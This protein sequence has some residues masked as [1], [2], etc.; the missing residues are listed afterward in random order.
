VGGVRCPTSGSEKRRKI[1]IPP[2]TEGL[3]KFSFGKNSQRLEM[4]TSDQYKYGKT[5]LGIHVDGLDVKFARISVCGKRIVLRNLGAVTL[6]SPLEKSP[7]KKSGSLMEGEDPFDVTSSS[8]DE[9]DVLKGGVTEAENNNSVMVNLF[10]RFPAK[11]HFLALTV[12]EPG[13]FYQ[14]LSSDFGLKGEKLKAKLVQELAKNFP[15]NT[16]LLPDRIDSITASDDSL[17]CVALRDGIPVLKLVEEVRPFIG[18]RLPRIS[19]AES[20]DIAL[21]NFVRANYNFPE[22]QTTVVIYIGAD[23]SRLIFLR[24]TEFLHMAPLISEGT[25]SRLIQ[26]TIYS[27]ILLEQ[28][29]SSIGK[30]DNILLAGSCFHLSLKE[31]MELHFRDVP[32]EYLES[33][34]LDMRQL[35][36]DQANLISEYAIPIAAAWRAVEDDERFYEVDLLPQEVKEGQKAL[37]LAWHG[38]AM[39]AL[40]FVMTV[41]FSR[42]YTSNVEEI[43]SLKNKLEFTRGQVEQQKRLVISIDSVKGSYSGYESA[44]SVMDSLVIGADKWSRTIERLTR[45]VGDVQSVWITDVRATSEGMALHG[46]ALYR[47]RIP[48]LAQLLG[49]ARINLVTVQKIRSETVYRFEMEAR[50][51]A[52]VPE[53]VN[54]MLQRAAAK[55]VVNPDTSLTPKPENQLTSKLLSSN[56]TKN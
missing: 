1:K 2:K 6:I 27:R 24:G 46:Y 7:S 42:Q 28:D 14:T 48:R 34:A 44:V 51:P 49:N 33:Q 11:K 45:H 41:L 3:L 39:L 55:Q 13:I 17:L 36:P 22:N 32:V 35:S 19:F 9:N 23:H 21:V 54:Q 15:T 40:L 53:I 5:A 18:G 4:A 56:N 30:I 10:S 31:S 25:S 37:K 38:Y 47:A 43:K 16:D 50:I 8:S 52:E 20:S 12:S 26:N 29:T